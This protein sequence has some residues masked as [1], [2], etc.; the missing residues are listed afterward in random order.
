MSTNQDELDFEL[1]MEPE[2][3]VLWPFCKKCNRFVP[4]DGENGESVQI[5]EVLQPERAQRVHSGIVTPVIR[6]WSG[7]CHGETF[8][9][10]NIDRLP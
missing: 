4:A 3:N 10:G 7:S 5:N 9:L 1:R 6:K 2:N 8:G